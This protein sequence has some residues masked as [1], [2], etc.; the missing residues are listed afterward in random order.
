[1]AKTVKALKGE[2]IIA[3]HNDNFVDSSL[4]KG[5][6]SIYE[7]TIRYVSLLETNDVEKVEK[8]NL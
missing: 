1:M 4:F 2:F 3:S 6:S 5:W 8:M 7:Y